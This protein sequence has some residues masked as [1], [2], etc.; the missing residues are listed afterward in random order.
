MSK[1][2]TLALRYG[3]AWGLDITA[4]QAEYT[5][6]MLYNRWDYRNITLLVGCVDNALARKELAK[7]LKSIDQ[8][9]PP[10]TWW[11]DAGNHQNSGQVNIGNA[12]TLSDLSIAFLYPNM[13]LALPSPALQ[14]PELLKPKPEEGGSKGGANLLSCADLALLN[15]QSLTINFKMAAE[16][17]DYVLRLLL[18]RDLTKASTY[19][20]L[21]SGVTT[22]YLYYAPSSCGYGELRP[23]YPV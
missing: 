13:C 16:L 5:S 4:V 18:T 22:L 21:P 20:D 12:P 19:L 1:A 8:N 15:A 11:L 10:T 3:L 7:S 14:H 9:R 2:R 23:G 17:S 6:D